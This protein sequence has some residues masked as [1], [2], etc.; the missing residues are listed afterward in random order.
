MLRI[1]QMSDEDQQELLRMTRQEKG[2]VALRAQLILWAYHDRQSIPRLASRM[3]WTQERVRHWIHRFLEKGPPGLYDRPGRGRPSKQTSSVKQALGEVLEEEMPPAQTGYTC[4]TIALLVSW[5]LARFEVKVHPSTLRRWIH[6][7]FHWNR[8]QT[9]PVSHDPQGDA[10]R[11]R[12]ADLKATV[13][14]PD[15][16]LYQDETTLRLLP[17]IRGKWMRIGTQSRIPTGSGWNRSFKVFGAL[18]AHSG[19]WTYRIVEK[20]NALS[21]LAFLQALLEAYPQ[22][23]IYVILDGASWH[24]AQRVQAWLDTQARI[25]LVWLPTGSP[26]LN[27]VERIWGKLKDQ[28]AANRWYG[29]PQALRT[30]TEHFLDSLSPE[31]ASQIAHLAA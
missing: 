5:L 29:T 28:V 2:S 7:D 23:R 22:G 1:T 31:K 16:F 24:R 17:V 25:E 26:K 13:Q 3:G 27:P 10:K 11:Q 14:A 6:S 8:P 9:H 15:V 20:C 30:V 21:F 4:W 19:N 12:M 18:D